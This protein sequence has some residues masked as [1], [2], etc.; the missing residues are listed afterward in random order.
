MFDNVV[1]INNLGMI[2]VCRVSPNKAKAFKK[3]YATNQLLRPSDN[4]IL[5]DRVVVPVSVSKLKCF[6]ET[7]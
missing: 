1:K 2:L 5:V 7:I 4:C 6:V 3:C